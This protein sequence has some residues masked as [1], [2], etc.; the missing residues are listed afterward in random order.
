MKSRP[1]SDK[2]P[3][4][5]NV[6]TISVLFSHE[7]H[8]NAGAL[9]LMHGSHC[10]FSSLSC[11]SF[12]LPFHC[13]QEKGFCA[14]PHCRLIASLGSSFAWWIF[15]LLVE[16]DWIVCFSCSDLDTNHHTRKWIP[17]RAAIMMSGRSIALQVASCVHWPETNLDWLTEEPQ[18]TLEEPLIH[19]NQLALDKT[20]NG[21]KFTDRVCWNSHLHGICSNKE[22][23][24]SQDV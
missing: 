11:P 2:H 17:M 12:F 9:E 1:C 14:L 23:V 7:I 22:S 21:K 8:H 6:K 5:N 24:G 13:F 18:Y 15:L 19:Q 10:D 3:W 16:K 4:R 20:I